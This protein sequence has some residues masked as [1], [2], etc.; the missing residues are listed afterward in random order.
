MLYCE[1]PH[2]LTTHQECKY[3]EKT[4]VYRYLRPSCIDTNTLMYILRWS[5]DSCA[6][7]NPKIYVI[8][9]GNS[10]FL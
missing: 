6:K 7:N 9:L 8:K 4:H 5:A 10:F 3:F 1:A 2:I